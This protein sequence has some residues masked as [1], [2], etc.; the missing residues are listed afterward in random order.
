M[1]KRG[2][3][4]KD[5]RGLDKRKAATKV[6]TDQRLR[7]GQLH[8][9]DTIPSGDPKIATAIAQYSFQIEANKQSRNWV[10][11]VQWVENLLFMA[12]R[13]YIDDILVSRLARDSDGNTSI[14]KEVNRQIPRPVNDLLGRYIETNVA[15]VTE[16]RPRPR[17][18]SKSDRREDQTAA[19]LSELTM[20]YLWEKMGLPEAHREIARIVLA[21][22]TCWIE[23]AHDPAM[24]R[25]ITVPATK[26]EQQTIVPDVAGGAPSV[27]IPLERQ[28]EAR[29]DKGNLVYESKLE[30]GDIST[31]IVSPFEMHMPVDNRWNGER[32]NWIMR[33]WYAGIEAFQD[34]YGNSDIA[35]ELTKEKGW[36]LDR[37]EDIG[38]LSIQNLPLWWWERLADLIEGPG[39]SLYVGTPETWTNHSVMRWFDRK[40]GPDWPKGRSILLAGN[41]VIYDSPKDIGARAYDQR[42]PDRW[43]P[44][45]RYR[46]EPLT[47]SI[48]GRSMV[49]KLLPKLKRVNAIDTTLIMW[50]RTVPISCWIAPKGCAISGTYVI[51][52]TGEIR[53]IQDIKDG[54]VQNKNGI[55]KVIK[56][57]EYYNDEQVIKLKAKGQFPLC[58]TSNHKIPVIPKPI[59]EAIKRKYRGTKRDYSSITTSNV[60]EKSM[61]DIKIGDHIFTGFHRDRSG[62]EKIYISNYY[63]P[64]SGR[65]PNPIP[66]VFNVDEKFLRLAGLYLAEGCVK[67]NR[68]YPGVIQWTIGCHEIDTLG[69][70]I[71]DSVKDI[72]GLD[73]FGRVE[74][75]PLGKAYQIKVH[76]SPLA[77]VFLHLFGTGSTKKKIAPEIFNYPGSLLPLI[78][79]WIDGDGCSNSVPQLPDGRK[80]TWKQSRASTT[81]KDL[82][83]QVRS[84]L[85]DE[86]IATSICSPKKE[87]DRK[88]QKYVLNWDTT[89]RR[90]LAPY[91]DKFKE[92]TSQ[93]TAQQGFWLDNWFAVPVKSVEG[94]EY[95]GKVYDLEVT[96]DHHYHANGIIVHN[97]HPVEDIWSGRPGMIYEYDP[98]RTAGK[99]PEPVM[100]PNYPEAALRERETQ[101]VEMESIAGTEEILRGQ[102]PSGVT[103]ATMLDVLRKQ[104]LAS[105]SSTLQSWDESLQELGALM[106]Q[107]TIRNVKSDHRYA[108]RIRILAREKHSR[109]TIEKFSGTDLSDNVIVRVDTASLA[110]VSKEAK[111][112][113]ALEFMQYAPG[114]MQL[115]L[116][117]RQAII[118]ELGFGKAMTPQGPD[119]E[120]AKMMI[121]WIK[122]GEVERLQPF[123]EDDP[124]IFVEL[125]ANEMKSDAF[126]DLDEQQAGA[127]L[128]LLGVYKQALQVQQEAEMKMMMLQQG[129]GGGGGGGAPVG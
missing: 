30:Y 46:G 44:Y 3:K 97:S 72:F 99:A 25:H 49:S 69:K 94:I 16:N 77:E 96:G 26:T 32:M 98:R 7:F 117:I 80:R 41:Q 125:L 13:H 100:P 64:R 61:G 31:R 53:E 106:L 102:R 109:L 47:G 108:E 22:G 24:P 86:K 128:K 114:L 89:A 93:K 63:L 19:E 50:R 17:I 60:I 81:S 42:W 107:V 75:N 101:I 35:K 4:P 2:R 38:I 58:M 5:Y 40:P 103:S 10:R 66:P 127:L 121:Q 84:I 45:V 105:R 20:E 113:K 51:S 90:A 85:L 9:L 54:K 12:G 23:C 62:E 124:Y 73:S 78:G 118:E 36:Y 111:E 14:A 6:T 112:Q 68:K 33:E 83:F 120:R 88:N 59:M 115:P 74:Y 91:C 87:K 122:Q 92:D 34:K 11:A 79:G 43:H 129:Q 48:Y 104:A 55:G 39:P 28:V 95:T 67:T 65:V 82:L 57:Y 70:E 15:L 71:I 29:D 56:Q 119:V 27:K 52:C 18:T 123:P 21:T 126:W 1:A 76:N 37:L 8:L 110:L 116:Q